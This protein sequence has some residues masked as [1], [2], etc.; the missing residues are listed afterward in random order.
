[1]VIKQYC[2]VVLKD[3]RRA[4]VVEVFSDKDFLADI[5]GSSKDWDTIFITIDESSGCSTKP[6]RRRMILYGQKEKP[7]NVM[8]GWI[9]RPSG[10]VSMTSAYIKEGEYHE[11]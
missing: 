2:S 5:G 6:P 4:C 11:D 8:V 10:E 1:M 7:A 3:G 9:L